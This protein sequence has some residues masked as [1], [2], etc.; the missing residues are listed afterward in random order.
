MGAPQKCGCK[1]CAERTLPTLAI[2]DRISRQRAR[3]LIRWAKKSGD[4]ALLTRVLAIEKVLRHG[5]AFRSVAQELQCVTS[6]VS[7]W[8]HRFQIADREGLLDRRVMNGDTKATPGFQQVVAEVLWGCPLDYGYNRPTWT[9]ELLV[10]VV[11]ARTGVKVS[12][13]VMG[14]VLRRMRARRGNPKPIVLCPLS[15]RQQCRR[16]AKIRRLIAELPANEVALYEDEA[17]I[18]LN[19]KIGLDWMPRGHQRL[20]I[21]PG[22][23]QKAY[24]AGALDARDGTIVW[25]GATQ[26]NTSL[27]IQLLEKLVMHYPNAKRIHIILDNYRIHSSG[28]ARRALRQLGCIQL[29][30]LPPYSPDHNRIERLW[31]NLHANVTRNHKHTTL[32]SLCQAVTHYLDAASPWRPAPRHKSNSRRRVRFTPRRRT[33]TCRHR[34]QIQL[35][36]QS[37]VPDSRSLI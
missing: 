24:V 10:L 28:E 36:P 30:F 4:A 13:C 33:T 1:S 12:V 25:T 22:K 6:S 7:R 27:F 11:Q 31:Q 15:L 9:R 26:K 8:V 19:P 29:H 18:H 3:S 34:P 21:T 37:S 23:N 32:E 17:D 16:L 14:R 2:V 20:V 35:S 5:T